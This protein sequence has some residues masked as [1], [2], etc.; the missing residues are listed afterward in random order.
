MPACFLLPSDSYLRA[1]A[2]VPFCCWTSALIF[3]HTNPPC[4][5]EVTASVACFW[6]E[7]RQF[8]QCHCRSYVIPTSLAHFE[9]RQH[10]S[11]MVPDNNLVQTSCSPHLPAHLH[12]LLFESANNLMMSA[13]YAP[14]VA[15]TGAP[16]GPKAVT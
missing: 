10:E 16:D 4:C 6:G 9:L 13:H 2:C 3:L 8:H 12:P 15:P 11:T 14:H 1:F 7:S 5:V